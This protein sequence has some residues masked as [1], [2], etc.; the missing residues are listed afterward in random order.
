MSVDQVK[1]FSA[2]TKGDSVAAQWQNTAKA[3]D[4]GNDGVISKAEFREAMSVVERTFN[5]GTPALTAKNITDLFSMFGAADGNKGMTTAE[6]GNALA[7]MSVAPGTTYRNGI[8]HSSNAKETMTGKSAANVIDDLLH[9]TTWDFNDQAQIDKH[10]A[11]AVPAETSTPVTKLQPADTEPAS[12]EVETT[13]FQLDQD[14]D[15]GEF[16]DQI[17]DLGVPSASASKVYGVFARLDGSYGVLGDESGAEGDR[18]AGKIQR[19]LSDLEFAALK[20]ALGELKANGQDVTRWALQ[21]QAAKSFEAVQQ[22]PVLQ[23][24]AQVANTVEAIDQNQLAGFLDAI[25]AQANQTRQFGQHGL[26]FQPQQPTVQGQTNGHPQQNMMDFLTAFE[27]ELA[28]EMSGMHRYGYDP[29]VFA[30]NT[31]FDTP[32]QTRGIQQ[33]LP[34]VNSFSKDIGRQKPIHSKLSEEA[35]AEMLEQEA[36][37]QD[38]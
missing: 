25:I 9:E 15:F 24:K 36:I 16:S 30:N 37:H 4:T 18:R 6:L 17:F 7:M 21:Q 20:H 34:P 3:F 10:Y 11:V 5:D 2:S 27:A 33:F 13:G 14:M 35:Y 8:G 22:Q 12:L 32:Y 26:N 23:E 29:N 1:G 38:I 31:T 28:S 19:G